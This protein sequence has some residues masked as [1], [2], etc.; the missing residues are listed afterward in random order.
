MP[1][2][3]PKNFTFRSFRR[4][5]AGRYLTHHGRSLFKFVKR[6]FPF[7]KALPLFR[8][9]NKYT[10]R[11]TLDGFFIFKFSTF[12]KQIRDH[13]DVTQC[14]SCRQGTVPDDTHS[15]CRDIPEEF[16]RPESGWAIGAMSFSAT[17]ILVSDSRRCNYLRE[18]KIA[19]GCCGVKARGEEIV[20]FSNF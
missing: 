8:E 10:A 1:A 15:A 13:K 16:L 5:M 7:K 11:I 2:I 3:E 14:I 4:E 20:A 19:S 18:N 6:K 17:G 9:R 12:V